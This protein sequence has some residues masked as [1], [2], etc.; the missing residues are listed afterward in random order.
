MQAPGDEIVHHVGA[1]LVGD[2][3]HLDAGELAELERE[4]LLRR[5]AP[6]HPVVE[7]AG[8][9]ARI[10]NEAL[11]VGGRHLVRGDDA[12]VVA[13]YLRNGSDVREL[14]GGVAID[15]E[16]DSFEVRAEEQVVA[17]ALS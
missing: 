14:V 1:A 15:G 8:I 10:G 12:V 6:D 2:A 7:L 13:R 16:I 3:G 17:I 5:A 9:G 4:D 11:P